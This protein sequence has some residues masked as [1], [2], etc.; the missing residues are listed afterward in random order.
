[1]KPLTTGE[2]HLLRLTAEGMIKTSDGWAIV[3]RTVW[4]LM[5]NLPAELIEL[6]S[7]EGIGGFAR[8]TDA[9]HAVVRYS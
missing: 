6:Q 8:L 2:K 5:A 4:P 1:M 7:C 3:P 9:G